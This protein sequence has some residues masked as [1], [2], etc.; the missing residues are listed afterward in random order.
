M[1]S[2]KS[3]LDQIAE[4]VRRGG[5]PCLLLQLGEGELGGAVDRNEEVELAFEEP[6]LFGLGELG[7]F[8]IAAKANREIPAKA[9]RKNVYR[10][11]LRAPSICRGKRPPA[12]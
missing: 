4:E 10:R 6:E 3:S 9:I 5:D 12:F 1:T 8:R 2:A 7:R 11:S